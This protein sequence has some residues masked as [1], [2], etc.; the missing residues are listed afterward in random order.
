MPETAAAVATDM[1]AIEL[2]PQDRNPHR[3]RNAVFSI[4]LSLAVIGAVIHEMG[5][6]DVPRLLS[7]VP[8]RPSFWIFFAAA[9]LVTPAS[10]WLIF[11]RLWRIPPAGFLALLRKKVYNELLLGYLGEAYFYTWARRRVSLD[12]APFGAVKDVA[13][14]SAMTGNVVTM[15]LLV[16]MLPLLGKTGLGVDTRMLALSLGVI[17]ALSLAA[18]VFRRRVFTLQRSELVMI[19]QTHLARIILSTVLSAVVWHLVLPEVPLSWWLY[20]ST[21]RLLVSR[22]P[23][24]PNKDLLFAGIAVLSLGHERDIGALMTLMAGLILA[25]HLVLGSLIAINDLANPEKRA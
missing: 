19:T 14:L 25:T 5:G 2:T 18:M 22:L 4:A 6:L 1:P 10:E 24:I 20:L 11:H 15:A 8:A 13:I 12:A 21:L 9:Y 17:L 7:M 3:G 16:V 23:L